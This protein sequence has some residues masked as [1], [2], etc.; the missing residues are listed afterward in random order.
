MEKKIKQRIEGNKAL[1][2]VVSIKPS[3]EMATKVKNESERKTN[4]VYLNN[5][6]FHCH[7]NASDCSDGNGIIG[8]CHNR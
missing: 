3:I 2:S 8:N 7:G 5:T 1:C 4:G 6:E